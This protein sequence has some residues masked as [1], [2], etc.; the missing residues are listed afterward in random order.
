MKVTDWPRRDGFR[1]DTIAV[2]VPAVFTVRPVVSA[3]QKV[4]GRG[5]EALPRWSKL[6]AAVGVTVTWQ[7]EAPAVVGARTQLVAESPEPVRATVPVGLDGVPL[8]CV[9]VTVTV[10]DVVWPTTTGL[11]PKAIAVFVVR[12]FTWRLNVWLAVCGVPGVES[13]TFAVN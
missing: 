3:A 12:A 7:A 2:A 5:R 9:S 1:L 8:P 4:H 13:D 6:P 10:T 11:A